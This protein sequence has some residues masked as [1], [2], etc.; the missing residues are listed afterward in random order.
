M[1]TTPFFLVTGFLGS[2][3][4]TLLKRFLLEHADARRVAVIQNEFA[5]GNVDGHE[6][7]DVGK[8]F[9]ILEINKGSVF[10]VCLLSDFVSSLSRLLDDVS[11]E[12]VILEA[13]GLAD[14]IAVAQLLQAPEL[15]DRLYLA[16][17][18]C[19]VDA[20]SFM[21]MVGAATRVSHQVRIADTV[22]INKVD[23]AEGQ[24]DE[25][26]AK[27]LELNPFAAVHHASHCEV[28][29]G[30][31]FAP[32]TEEPV[33]VRRSSENA[34]LESSG[35]PLVGS[36]A[37][38]TTRPVDRASLE[39]FVEA[40]APGT[41]RLKGYVR[42]TDGTT[43]VIQSCFGKTDIAAVAGYTGPSEVVAMGPGVEPRSFTEAFENLGA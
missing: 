29:L 34:A 40:E 11:P 8:P 25:V 31:L 26:E 17:A 1:S 19:I 22:I 20:S 39:R 15:K 43:V 13:T 5:P 3:K 37:V 9:E 14:P 10:C 36:V 28:P 35:R 32:L 16:H 23:L 24:L 12:A 21:R 6:L 18:F 7:R 41:Y 33:A 27:V 38:R 42:L 2:G 30:D 4:T